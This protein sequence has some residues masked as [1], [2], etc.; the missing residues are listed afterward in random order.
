MRGLPVAL[1]YAEPKTLT[2][3]K[4]YS[5]LDCSQQQH[6]HHIFNCVL[7]YGWADSSDWH[8]RSS[9]K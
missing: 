6:H 1:M 9:R 8:R 2:F 5:Y 3:L 7:H 4:Y